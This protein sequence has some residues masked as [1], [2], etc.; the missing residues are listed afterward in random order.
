MS[1][2]TFAKLITTPESHKTYLVEIEPKYLIIDWTLLSGTTYYTDL[3]ATEVSALNEDGT[4][5]TEVETLAGIAAGK[6]YHAKDKIYVQ[7]TTGLPQAKTM[8]AAM[9]KYY[10]TED[11]IFGD[12]FYEG[13]V[14]SIPVIKQ[15]KSEVYYG[16][17]GISKGM[18]S[19]RNSLGA[20]DEI[21]KKYAWNNQKLT[22]LLGGEDLPYSEYKKMFSGKITDK[23]LSTGMM[24]IKYED[25]K[26]D[27]ETDI[28][29]N[30]FDATT[31]PNLNTEDIGRAIPLIHGTV[32]KVPAICTTAALG[33][34]TSSH[35]FKICDTSVCSL[36]AIS[37][38][39]VNDKGVSFLSSSI[40]TASFKLPT[41]TFSVGDEVT[42]TVIANEENPIEQI[43]AIASN[44]LSISYDSDN[45]ST[46][47]ISIASTAAADYKCGTYIGERKPFLKVI[48]ELMQSCLGS[49]YSDNDGVYAINIWDVT[50]ESDIP[51]V[52]YN[53]IIDGSLKINAKVENIRKTVRVGWRRAWGKNK[54]SYKQ[55][56]SE[57]TEQ[58]YGITRSKTIPTYLSDSTSADV[59]LARLGL[60]FESETN[61][62]TFK[63]K[64]QLAEQNIGD[65]IS[66]SFKRNDT[67]DYFEWIDSAIV[68]INEITKDLLKNEITIKADD[69]KGVGSGVG[70]WAAD[71]AVFPSFYG[72]GQM[73][74]WDKNWTLA[75]KAYAKAH[76]GMWCDDNGFADPDDADSW[77]VSRFW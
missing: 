66:V 55:S 16:V 6:W 21:Y 29:V 44:V 5:L 69:L 14:L 71:A 76:T 56:T 35:S 24:D 62:I 20:L 47:S 68:E 37:N 60:M 12:N 41:A 51:H 52:D 54:Y 30:S 13:I 7:C 75:Q 28:P 9:K 45:F 34:S 17:S 42:T 39:Y 1:I 19:L 38:V 73:S 2:T 3:V 48:G 18:L 25:T 61:N 53:H 67:D 40:S 23:N 36:S 50:I 10:A 27:L 22:V 11:K 15:K 46:S 26:T 72:G 4:A 33:S 8:V 77:N 58:L 57:S 65:R 70:L 59:L 49:F 43:K 64:I 32:F 74:A 31:Y 63:S